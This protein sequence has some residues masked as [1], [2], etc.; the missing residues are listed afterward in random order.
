MT[1]VCNSQW[2][3]ASDWFLRILRFPSFLLETKVCRYKES[4]SASFFLQNF[5]NQ[6]CRFFQVSIVGLQNVVVNTTKTKELQF[7]TLQIG[8]FK[9]IAW[10]MIFTYTDWFEKFNIGFPA[11]PFCATYLS[12]N[13]ETRAFLLFLGGIERD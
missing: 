9:I 4:R 5:V 6:F 1:S 12:E 8:I 13:R 7:L 11:K 10:S 2:P 3:N